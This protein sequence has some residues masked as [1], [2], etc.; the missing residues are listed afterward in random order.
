MKILELETT[1]DYKNSHLCKQFSKL[2]KSWTSIK[3]KNIE[4]QIG[5]NPNH[6][7]TRI[8]YPIQSSTGHT[9]HYAQGL[10]IDCLVFDPTS[11]IKHGLT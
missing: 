9:I 3:Q 5:N 10:T 1:Q 4:I 6:T 7:I 11:V 2:H 8:Q